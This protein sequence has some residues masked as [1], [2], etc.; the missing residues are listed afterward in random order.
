[1]SNSPKDIYATYYADQFN[2]MFKKA[3]VKHITN[4][5]K[6]GF[7]EVLKKYTNKLTERRI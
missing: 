5:S 1:M 6:D 7:Y 3:K 2:Q 4:V